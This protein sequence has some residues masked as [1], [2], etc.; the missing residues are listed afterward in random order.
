VPVEPYRLHPVAPTVALLTPDGEALSE[1]GERLDFDDWPKG[2]RCYASYDTVYQLVRAGRGEAL[3]WNREEVKWRHRRR[4]DGPLGWHPRPSD[5]S[6]IRLAFD[7][8]APEM[9]LR[10]LALWRDWLASYRAAPTGTTGSAA[11]SLLRA[12][13]EA[14]L[15]TRVGDMPPLKF[16]CGGRIEKGPRGPGLYTGDLS[17]FDLP[18]AYASE[19]GQ[20]KYGGRWL[21]T[22]TVN[23]KH[24]PEWWALEGRPV[25]VRAIVRVPDLDFGLL[26]RRPSRHGYGYLSA[27]L[28]QELPFPRGKRVQGVWTWQELETAISYGAKV[29][30]ILGVWAHLAST[31][32]FVPWWEAVQA[33]RRMPGLA[34]VLAK[35]TGNAL[36]GRFAMDPT[37]AGERH[38][39]SMNGK[40]QDRKLWRRPGLPA[41]HA[42]AETVSGRVRAKLTAA[43]LAAGTNLVCAHTDGLWTE[44][45][46]DPPD[47]WR[48]DKSA[49]RV[50]MLEPFQLRWYPRGGGGPRVIMAGVPHLLAKE[51]F[52]Q[53]W[54]KGG[55]SGNA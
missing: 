43:M 19:L 55:F 5:V 21:D 23:V 34:G 25:F 26:L 45:P 27:M 32:P 42:L 9:T 18:A 10:A 3:T 28:Q 44:Q 16:T 50:D 6:V 11:W 36:W 46:G 12:R 47:G 17:H 4:D 14:P 37:L 22:S 20:L 48:C 39:R 2:V 35:A 51:T 41:D 13:L 54:Q 52:E 33:G 15:W 38:I 49:R 24:G 8:D 1:H 53:R 7:D 40:L 30:R 31:R 29:Q